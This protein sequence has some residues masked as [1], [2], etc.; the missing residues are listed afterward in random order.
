[1]NEAQHAIIIKNVNKTVH[2]PQTL[3]KYFI[4]TIWDN[5]QLLYRR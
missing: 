2:K 4:A 5:G 3:I 1:M